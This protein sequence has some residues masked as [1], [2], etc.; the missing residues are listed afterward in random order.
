MKSLSKIAVF[1]TASAFCIDR[2]H[3]RRRPRDRPRGTD[4][5]AIRKRPARGYGP[6]PLQRSKRYGCRCRH[7]H[8]TGR[9]WFPSPHHGE[10][11]RSRLLQRRWSPE[12]GRRNARGA[13][14]GRQTPR[15]HAN[16]VIGENR[17]GSTQVE[18]DGDARIVL[19]NIFD[20]DGTAV[21][22]HAGADDYRTDPSGNAGSRI[23]CGVLKP[24]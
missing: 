6:T 17:S 12:P 11:Y 8:V 14:T 13:F 1:A 5:I 3:D 15:R 20:A 22:V 2:L 10:V 23:A 24:A 9:T 19:E 16:L 18:L 21:V 7:R 4:D